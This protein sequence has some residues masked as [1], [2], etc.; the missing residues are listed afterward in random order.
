MRELF[1]W[2]EVAEATGDDSMSVW[3]AGTLGRGGRAWAHD[4]AALVAAPALSLHDRAVVTGP[5]DAVATLVEHAHA[6]LGPAYRPYADVPLIDALVHRLPHLCKRTPFG[7]MA[8]PP[9]RTLSGVDG[10]ARW[11]A[12][13]ELPEAGDLLDRV[14]PSS[15]ARPGVPGVRRWAG[16]RDDAGGLVAIGADAWSTTSVGLISGVVTDP[17]AR[18][19]GL[20]TRLCAF[21][22]HALLTEHGRA[23]LMVD[24]WNTAAIRLYERLGLVRRRVVACAAR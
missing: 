5:V 2:Q 10:P 1:T 14:Y 6:E 15:Y 8:T 13:D 19:T 16:I 24:D 11:L 22:V 7:W 9:G 4:G 12:D 20:G 17:A 21:L 23:A 18:G 3:A